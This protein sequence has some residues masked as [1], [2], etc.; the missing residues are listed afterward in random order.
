MKYETIFEVDL[1][2]LKDNTKKLVKNFNNYK[3]IGANLKNNAHGLGLEV[4]STLSNSGIDYVIIDTLKDGIELRK[5][6]KDIEIIVDNNLTVDEVYD[7]INNN[8]NI[9]IYDKDYFDIINNLKIKDNLNVEIMVDN[10]SNIV[11]INN[12][13]DIE[14]IINKINDN[15][16]LNLKGIY[17]FITTMGIK[18]EYYYKQMDN[19]MSI[20][21]DFGDIKIHLNE[22]IMYH[23]KEK[24][25]NGI[26]FDLSLLGIEEVI[27]EDIF[28]KSKIK[29]IEKNY[30]NIITPN[31]DLELVFN[32]VSVISKISIVENNL[33]GRDYY[34]KDSKYVG[35]IPLGHKDGITKNIKYVGVNGLKREVLTDELDKLYI[36]VDEDIKVGDKVYVL[37][38]ERDIYRFINNLHTSRNYLMSIL[39]K[40]LRKVYINKDKV[41]KELL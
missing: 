35:I 29:R 40:N 7:A 25:I 20:I 14:Y 38:E 11:G 30:G 2:K 37:N 13:S 17:S 24:C 3:Y 27:E 36:Q 15:K 34:V 9:T 19:F 31:I 1:K 33:V 22:A 12:K 8:I 21:N 10:G 39:N 4:I 32:I 16:Y 6:D 28:T 26:C 5:Y 41:S 23:E 18:E